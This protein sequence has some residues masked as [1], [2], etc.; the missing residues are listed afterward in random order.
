MHKLTVRSIIFGLATA[1]LLVSLTPALLMYASEEEPLEEYYGWFFDITFPNGDMAPQWT[2]Y[3]VQK[4]PAT[5][6]I[7]NVDMRTQSIHHLCSDHGIMY[8]TGMAHFDGQ[9]SISCDLPDFVTEL[10]R[11]FGI[12]A[13]LTSDMGYDHWI[14][15][16]I[17][18]EHHSFAP[19]PQT[20]LLADLP[21]LWTP[22]TSGIAL[23]LSN[24]LGGPQ[25]DAVMNMFGNNH[26]ARWGWSQPGQTLFWAG[27]NLS[28]FVE[29][30]KHQNILS[31][32]ATP[33]NS[34]VSVY[35]AAPS[36]FVF[37]ANT[38]TAETIS[39]VPK[40]TQLFQGG[41]VYIG[42]DPTQNI[43]F[44]GDMLQLAADPGL[45]VH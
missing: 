1:I 11:E 23:A 42:C 13:P 43:C 28:E 21:I 37:W 19:D 20:G 18:L 34:E 17:M 24:P 29:L 41:K 36:D 14:A 9:S 33:P 10:A 27:H 31:T 30:A 16:S 44:L 15:G 7:V 45:R 3:K 22:G 6:Q 12:E 25:V 5:Q 40:P 39:N 4:H 26:I 2:I 38:G 35:T 32:L 8:H